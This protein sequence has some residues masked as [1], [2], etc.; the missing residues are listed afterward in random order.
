MTRRHFWSEGRIGGAITNCENGVI[1]MNYLVIWKDF[2]VF[3]GSHSRTVNE[4]SHPVIQWVFAIRDRF[5]SKDDSGNWVPKKGLLIAPNCPHECDASNIPIISVQIDPESSL[6]EWIMSNQLN[7]Q[8]IIDYPSKDIVSVDTNRFSDH[9]VHEDW[10][11]LRALIE[12][13]FGFR[14]ATPVFQ[15]DKRIQDVVA[16]ISKNIGQEIHSETL[17]EVACLSESRLLHLFKEEM[18]LPIRNYILWLR[19][20]IVI[21]LMLEG[22]SLTTASH[23]AGFSDQA[24]L[25]RTFSNMIGVPPSLIS[26]HSR[27]VQVSTPG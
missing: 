20:Q 2:K 13:A 23:E 19:L 26:K 15:K 3:Y 21:E 18:G 4:H 14:K 5:L 22:Q 7:D 8:L 10:P 17:A 24:H 16:F 27:F 12:T 11:A 1:N 6:G 25:T 9:I